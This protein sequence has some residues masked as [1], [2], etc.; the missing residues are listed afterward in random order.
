MGDSA[1]GSGLRH[2]ICGDIYSLGESIA[3]Y[4]K[5]KV[6]VCSYNW[7]VVRTGEVSLC[8][9]TGGRGLSMQSEGEGKR[10]GHG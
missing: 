6:T 8:W 4:Q 3:F 5:N 2:D 1:P 7:E 10:R 9:V